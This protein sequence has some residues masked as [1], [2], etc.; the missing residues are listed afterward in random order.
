MS[1]IS[2]SIHMQDGSWCDSRKHSLL[3]IYL[4]EGENSQDESSTQLLHGLRNTG[5]Q[6]HLFSPWAAAAERQVQQIFKGA[7]IQFLFV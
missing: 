2:S 6:L 4:C 5:W 1:S 7:K 3:Q